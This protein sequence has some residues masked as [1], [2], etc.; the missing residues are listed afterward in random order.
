MRN[1]TNAK[2]DQAQVPENIIPLAGSTDLIRKKVNASF[3]IKIYSPSIVK[4]KLYTDDQRRENL[5]P[6]NSF[7]GEIEKKIR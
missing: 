6:E 4:R 7:D 2:E 1:Q 3:N 5:H